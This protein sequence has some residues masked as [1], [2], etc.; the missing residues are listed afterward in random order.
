MNNHYKERTMKFMK[1]VVA[2]AVLAVL[3]SS[4]YAS[5]I[6][7]IIN[8]EGAFVLEDDSG[9]YHKDTN[10]DGKL[11]VGESLRGIVEFPTMLG[12]ANGSTSYDLDG[13]TNEHL[14]AIFE[15]EVLAVD[16]HQGANGPE[17][18]FTFGPSADFATEFSAAT[19]TMFRFFT[20][21]VD[22][23]DILGSS[24]QAGDTLMGGVCEGTVSNGDWLMDVGFSGLDDDEGWKA[25][26]APLETGAGAIAQLTTSL[27]TF[28]YNLSLL[29]N[30]GSLL[31]LNQINSSVVPV[32]GG[33]NPDGL[34][35]F[36]GSGQLLGTL[37]PAGVKAT[38]YGFTND[39]DLSGYA[40]V[41]EPSSIAL[42][43]LALVGI[44]GAGRR[45]FKQI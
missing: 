30:A 10:Q 44:A 4:S 19:G 8:T 25:F 17:Y 34:T 36:T 27:G 5:S 26:N 41:P 39:A 21:D 40:R 43:G 28:N 3:A 29:D 37:D 42:F 33:L 20:D 11:D 6:R 9:E 35:D 24:C 31:N 14:S 15:V 32:A 12:F 16:A 2:G 45:K 7:S 23:V 38:G 13:T 18:T 22:D 1:K